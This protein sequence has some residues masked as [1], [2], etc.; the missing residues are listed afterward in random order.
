MRVREAWCFLAATIDRDSNKGLGK[1]GEGAKIALPFSSVRFCSFEDG[2]DPPCLGTGSEEL[3]LELISWRRAR[4]RSQA[5]E[6]LFQFFYLFHHPVEL[7][8]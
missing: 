6:F 8:G 3:S 5:F 7:P 2:L 1:A 4:A